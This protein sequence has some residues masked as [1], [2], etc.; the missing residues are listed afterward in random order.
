VKNLEA[1]KARLHK[2][3]LE[4]EQALPLVYKE[5]VAD[6]QVQDTA[7]QALASSLE[8]IKISLH[9]NELDEYQ[10]V[11]RALAMIDKGDYGNCSECNAPISE[12]RLEMFPYATRCLV[13]QEAH[14][15]GPS[16]HAHREE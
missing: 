14:E 10:M 3:K 15:E 2:R 12:R 7:D 9:D 1:T 5:K 13:C 16:A 11:L 8:G 4:L 6:D